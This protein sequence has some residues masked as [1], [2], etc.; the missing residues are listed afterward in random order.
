[1]LSSDGQA[2]FDWL[3]WLIGFAKMILASGIAHSKKELE[4]QAAQ[5]VMKKKDPREAIFLVLT[6]DDKKVLVEL[7]ALSIKELC[8]SS[9]PVAE[10]AF[11]NLTEVLVVIANARPAEEPNPEDQG[12]PI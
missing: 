9:A 7:A 10:F 4:E 6:K 8:V 2:V 5:S 3:S 1:M 12:F 11:E